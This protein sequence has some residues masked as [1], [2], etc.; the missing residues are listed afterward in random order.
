[1]T[2]LI[3]DDLVVAISNSADVTIQRDATMAGLDD[4]CA[5]QA[6]GG[7]VLQKVVAAGALGRKDGNDQRA[8][9]SLCKF[10]KFLAYAGVKF[11]RVCVQ[12]F[13]VGRVQH[14][15]YSGVAA[16]GRD[17]ASDV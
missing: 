3:K 5:W 1:M 4:L 7:T 16:A 2:Q 6:K 9:N 10:R 13:S 17:V 12:T 11:W 8:P 15:D 14:D